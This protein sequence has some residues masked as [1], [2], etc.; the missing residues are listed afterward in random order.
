MNNNELRRNLTELI[1][2]GQ[3]LSRNMRWLGEALEKL[4]DGDQGSWHFFLLHH[5]VVSEKLDIYVNDLR[6]ESAKH[7]EKIEAPRGEG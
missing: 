2:R 6:V 7:L 1:T 4:H 3:S 5:K